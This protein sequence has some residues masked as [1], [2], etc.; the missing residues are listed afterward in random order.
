MK[1]QDELMSPPGESLFEDT[2]LRVKCDY[3]DLSDKFKH[4]NKDFSKQYAHI[5]SVRLAKMRKTL[6]KRV[7][8]KFGDQWKVKKLAD[9]QD[10]SDIGKCF[11]IGTIFKNQE[12][13]PSVL[14]ELSDELQIVPQPKVVRFVGDKDSLILEDDLQ[15]I[16]LVG[17][18]DVHSIV[19]GVVVAVLGVVDNTGKF[20]VEQV[21]FSGPESPSSLTI[22][23]K[24]PERYLVILSGLDLAA[25]AD[26][27]LSLRMFTDW[28][29]GWLGGPSDQHK[30]S[31]IALVLIAGNMLRGCSALKEGKIISTNIDNTDIVTSLKLADDLLAE[32]AETVHVELMPG[33]FD[34]TNYT[35]PQQP[36]HYTM[37]PKASS[38]SSLHGVTNPHSFQVE[39]RII[40]GI[41]FKMFSLV[42]LI[43]TSLLLAFYNL[44]YLGCSLH[45]LN[46][47]SRCMFLH[48][49]LSHQLFWSNL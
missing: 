16:R 40:T 31:R 30:N 35:L 37:F 25:A 49:Y 34:P 1:S 29:T 43:I 27:L 8:D 44:Q 39:N 19:T 24:E 7:E 33:E 14:K 18:I 47:G 5:Y 32:L 22:K 6:L 2:F 46:L 41:Y 48:P 45:K 28:V 36:I 42:F 38:F 9:L 13:R 10:E 26:S 15:R 12:L 3:G 17:N 23:T 21:C 20:N 4:K 11:V